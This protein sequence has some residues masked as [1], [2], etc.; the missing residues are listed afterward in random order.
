MNWKLE[1]A[2]MLFGLRPIESFPDLATEALG[3][4]TDTPSLRILAGL[5]PVQ[6]NNDEIRE[7]LQKSLHELSVNWPS[8]EEA[9]WMLLRHYI[10][11]IIDERIE[12]HAGLHT[13]IWDIYHRMRWSESDQHY[14]GDCIKIEKLYGLCDTYDDLSEST[15]RWDEDKTNE[16]LKAQLQIDIRTEAQNY[17]EKFLSLQKAFQ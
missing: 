7:Y 9:T 12:P 8:E 16:E 3:E 15:H 17:K 5:T 2:K 4:G 11:E 14:A 6:K 13:I 10:D 1:L